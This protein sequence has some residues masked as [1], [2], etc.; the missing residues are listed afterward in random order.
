MNKKLSKKELEE[1]E[2]LQAHSWLKK[3]SRRIANTYGRC[4]SK[5]EKR[6]ASKGLRKSF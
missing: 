6:A 1:L 5:K 4:G 2:A 3:Q